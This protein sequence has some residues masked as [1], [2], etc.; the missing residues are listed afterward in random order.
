VRF[1]KL[2][3]K[4]KKGVVAFSNSQFNRN[5]CAVFAVLPS[6]IL[7]NKKS[8][9]ESTSMIQELYPVARGVRQVDVASPSR[10]AEL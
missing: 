5:Q 9:L 10:F 1:Y 7:A 8:L 2:P 4:F 3:W 6:L